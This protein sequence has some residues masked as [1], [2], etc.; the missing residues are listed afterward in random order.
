M[1]LQRLRKWLQLGY[2][3]PGL[4]PYNVTLD[5]GFATKAFTT[6]QVIIPEELE[7]G[8]WVLSFRWDCEESSQCALRL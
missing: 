3:G 4:R 2:C 7:A 8:H 1:R 6:T 5:L